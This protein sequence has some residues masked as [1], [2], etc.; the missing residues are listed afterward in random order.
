MTNS[1]IHLD[2][3]LPA[4]MAPHHFP[5]EHSTTRQVIIAIAEASDT[6]LT[7]TGLLIQMHELI[8]DYDSS[9]TS[10]SA[11]ITRTKNPSNISS[12]Y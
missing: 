11:L 12:N 10:T 2:D 4:H 7:L 9:K 5:E 1:G 8:R 6:A 3:D